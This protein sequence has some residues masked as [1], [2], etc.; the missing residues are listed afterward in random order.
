MVD[1]KKTILYK[2]IVVYLDSHVTEVGHVVINIQLNFCNNIKIQFNCLL[3][4]CWRE[5]K[6]EISTLVST[7]E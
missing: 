5:G 7:R 6:G 1:I 3:I 4:E 2:T